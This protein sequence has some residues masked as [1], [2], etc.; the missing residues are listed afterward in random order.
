MRARTL[1][2]M[3]RRRFSR[4]ATVALIIVGVLAL[5]SCQQQGEPTPL[6][7]PATAIPAISTATPIIEPISTVVPTETP[8]PTSAPITQLSIAV[9]EIPAVLP[10]YDRAEWRHWIDE[11]GDCQGARQEVLI[12]ESRIEITFT[13]GSI[14]R[15]SQ[16]Q[17][18]GA[19][20][21]TT[22]TE[23]G[24]LDID[25]FVPLANAH[26]SGGWSWNPER[27]KAF[28]NSLDDPDHL[29]AV[30][31]GANRSKGAR[32]P[33]EWRPPNGSYW[34]EYAI[35]WIRI[36]HAWDLTATPTEADA[37]QEMLATCDEIVELTTTVADA[38]TLIPIPAPISPAGGV[39]STCD[40]AE[41]AGE[42]RVQ[43][44]S[45]PGRGF[46]SWKVP[47]ARDGDGD[48]VVCER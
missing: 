44:T 30:T 9:S 11:D 31:F 21:G 37:L 22:V 8:A 16:G 10:K 36:K 23:P 2:L 24:E 6:R 18:F 25:H 39:Y 48:G 14:C 40:E 4:L 1:N 35:D 32:G 20:T 38:P 28:A 5:L 26:R 27:K 17:W 33:D 19:Y 34:C 7:S 42:P 47:G 13:S 15:V 12:E 41:A 43:G 45:G 29:I 3:D 46:P